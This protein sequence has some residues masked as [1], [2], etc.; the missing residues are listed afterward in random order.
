M[1]VIN[2]KIY[3]NTAIP[4]YIIRL[5]F[6]LLCFVVVDKVVWVTNCVHS[7]VSFVVGWQYVTLFIRKTA[8]LQTNGYTF[9]I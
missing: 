1:V 2:L 4:G 5:Y 9:I 7:V 8:I 3:W 6:K